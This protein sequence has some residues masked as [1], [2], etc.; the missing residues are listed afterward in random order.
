MELK[1]ASG[2]KHLAALPEE[3]GSVPRAMSRG[4]Q[5]LTPFHGIRRLWHRQA[6]ASLGRSALSFHRAVPRDWTQV[7]RLSGK[8]VYL[9]RHSFYTFGSS[10]AW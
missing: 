10:W 6:T 5:P 4:S 8:D 2:E 1:L 3:L 9:M 7:L